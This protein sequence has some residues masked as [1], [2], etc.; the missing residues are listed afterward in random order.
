MPD[1]HFPHYAICGDVVRA[2]DGEAE[3]PGIS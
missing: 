1:S 2:G 3:I